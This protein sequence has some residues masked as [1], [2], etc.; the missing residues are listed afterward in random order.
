MPR[1]RDV[2]HA[3]S[4][5][6]KARNVG[7]RTREYGVVLCAPPER[8]IGLYECECIYH[9]QVPAM[10]NSPKTSAPYNLVTT[11][12]VPSGKE[13][14]SSPSRA[15]CAHAKGCRTP[16]VCSLSRRQSQTV[17]SVFLTA[18]P[19]RTTFL[20][21]LHP[22]DQCDRF[23]GTPSRH[24]IYSASC[25]PW[26]PTIPTPTKIIAQCALCAPLHPTPIL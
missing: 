11:L 22:E 1:S 26:F 3:C 12:W 24:L 8:Y 20:G 17:L 5:A 18:L 23:C 10:S 9:H 15:P 13:W 14:Q 6:S 4:A 19:A 7:K 25:R 2:S 21:C 16:T